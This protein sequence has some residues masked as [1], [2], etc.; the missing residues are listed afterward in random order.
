MFISL[1]RAFKLNSYYL[2][3]YVIFDI[4]LCIDFLTGS[5]MQILFLIC[6]ILLEQTLGYVLST[7]SC[8]FLHSFFILLNVIY[9]ECVLCCIMYKN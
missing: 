8:I 7:F 9:V 5:D 6:L 1:S 4:F 3:V 2:F